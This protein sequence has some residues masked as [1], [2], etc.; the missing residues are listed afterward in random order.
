ME[1]NPIHSIMIVVKLM[2]GLGNQMFQYAAGRRLAQHHNTQLK[3][4]IS[5]LES[6]QEGNT[7]RTYKLKHLN[8]NEN[9]ATPTEINTIKQKGTNLRQN[10][11]RR[12]CHMIGLPNIRPNVYSER[13]FHFD[14]AFLIAPENIYI[15]GYWQSEKYF[16]DIEIIIRKEFSVKS[17]LVGKN[18]ELAELINITD[19]VS[20]HVRRGDFV[21]DSKTMATHGVCGAEYYAR[22]VEK[23]AS[24]VKAPLFFV[25]SDEPAWTRDNIRLPFPMAVVEHNTQDNGSED[26]RL[27]SLCRHNII[28]NS[29]FS[30]WGAWLNRN[31]EK[32]VIA[33]EKWFNDTSINTKDLIPDGWVK[34]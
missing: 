1:I 14:P 2:G 24:E 20:F 28:A 6:K 32:I 25:F 4:D 27:M 30:W 8:I 12:L 31:P 3:L 17:P 26:L 10:L 5:F 19:S 22:C 13:H 9:I 29:T 34:L 15:E 11:I 7:P 16:K 18:R 23:I 21:A 33:P